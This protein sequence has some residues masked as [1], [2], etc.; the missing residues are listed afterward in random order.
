MGCC[1]C[2]SIEIGN[3]NLDSFSSFG[4]YQERQARKNTGFIDLSLISQDD[5]FITNDVMDSRKQTFNGSPTSRSTAISL[6]FKD[7]EAAFLVSP[8]SSNRGSLIEN[9]GNLS[10][11]TPRA[12]N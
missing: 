7:L 9:F 5:E 8:T 12:F 2:T 1:Q 3:T 10:A 11:I 4:D 6:H